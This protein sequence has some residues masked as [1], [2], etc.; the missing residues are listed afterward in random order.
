[1]VVVIISDFCLAKQSRL[2]THL[3][4]FNEQP[5]YFSHHYYHYRVPCTIGCPP[6]LLRY[7]F[8]IPKL[9][10]PFL[11]T[12]FIDHFHLFLSSLNIQKTNNNNNNNQFKP[13]TT[14]FKLLH[15]S[16]KTKSIPIDGCAT[17]R[18]RPGIAHLYG[19][20]G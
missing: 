19:Y 9:L 20:Q 18:W 6:I 7:V 3:T 14:P 8:F 10:D 17:E 16:T 2:R 5:S 12:I 11:G 1:M 4:S 15:S 13:T